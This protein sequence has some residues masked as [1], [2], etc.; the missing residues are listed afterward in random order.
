MASLT[1]RW[2]TH[3][4]NRTENHSYLYLYIHC[5]NGTVLYVCDYKKKASTKIPKPANPD[6]P[7]RQ[8]RGHEVSD[9]R[10]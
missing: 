8:D 3:A 1:A 5:T 10:E 7:G 9:T 2:I 4:L 6:T